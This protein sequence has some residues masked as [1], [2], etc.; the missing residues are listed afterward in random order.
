MMV[1]G[2][3]IPKFSQEEML[4]RKLNSM[5]GGLSRSFLGRK[6]LRI[7]GINGQQIISLLGH[8]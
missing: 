4:L 6:S 2:A 7:I 5:W 3:G 1:Y 8:T